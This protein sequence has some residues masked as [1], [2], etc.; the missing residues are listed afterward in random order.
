MVLII[1]DGW[2]RGDT[3][4]LEQGIRRLQRSVSRL[5]WLNP[6]LGTEGYQPLVQG[7][8]TV[9]PHVDDFLPIH[10]LYSLQQ[11]V[12]ALGQA[13]T[14]AGRSHRPERPTH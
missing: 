13:H 6:L 7:I 5:I 9:L 12:A 4:L 14:R 2:D 3:A 10:N 1:S 11:L 8:E